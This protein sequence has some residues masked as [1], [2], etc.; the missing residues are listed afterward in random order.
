MEISKKDWALFRSKIGEW[1]EAYMHRLNQEYIELLSTEASPAEKFWELDK[2]LREDKRKPGVQLQL[3]KSNV[4]F[5]LVSLLSDGAISREDL[6]EFSDE[7][8]EAVD[9]IRSGF[10]DTHRAL[11]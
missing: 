6:S 4:I 9:F 8:Q 3:Q 5:D 10:A 11:H 2:R 1:Q 7:L